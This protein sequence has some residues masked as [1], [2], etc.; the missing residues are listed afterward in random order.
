MTIL[1]LFKNLNP[2]VKPYRKLVI[3]TL[4]LTLIGSFTA[5]VNALILQYTVDSI[6]GLVEAGKD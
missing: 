6:N 2:Y 5:Q 1:Q 3:A 4:T